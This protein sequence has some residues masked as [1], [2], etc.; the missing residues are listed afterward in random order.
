[1]RS[2]EVMSTS[3]LTDK[4]AR[5]QSIEDVLVRVIAGGET[6]LA[7]TL[8]HP[9]FIN[10]EA[11]PEPSHG[12]E[13]FART[14]AWLRSCF[15]TISWDFHHVVVD[16]DMAAAHVTMHGTHEGGLPPGAPP[17]HKPFA[18]RHIH[19]FRFAEDGRALEH[20]AVRDDVGLMMQAGL[21]GT[22]PRA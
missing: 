20:W 22:H 7:A 21:L 15:G 17:T 2:D 1:M 3:K 19:L 16:G 8:M 4:A 5:R 18:I 11:D 13:G 10:H 6:P 9:D 14:S 12:P